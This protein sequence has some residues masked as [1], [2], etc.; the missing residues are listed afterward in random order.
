[1]SNKIRHESYVAEAAVAANLIVR[2]G[3]ADG[4]CTQA[5]AATDAL[6]GAADSLDKAA[7]EMVDVAIG[8]F[9]EVRLG[10]TVTRGAWLT[11]N[12]VGRAIATTT[13][14]HQVIGR[15][16]QAGVADDVIRYRV[17]PGQL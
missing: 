2:Y 12:A 11:A 14:G 1:M 17:A 5:T 4:A 7:N 6:I 15:A 9:G 16:E 3:S 13:T 10:G 8:E